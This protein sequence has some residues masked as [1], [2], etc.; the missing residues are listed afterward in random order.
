[1]APLIM[2]SVI[3]A[4]VSQDHMIKSATSTYVDDIFINESLVPA[5]RVQQHFWTMVWFPRS[6]KIYGV[7]RHIKDLQPV[8]RTQLSSSDKSNFED[9]EHLIYLN[10]NLLDSDSDA[11]CL[12]TDEVSIKT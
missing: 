3:N 4:I 11:S 2:K 5:S 7:P 6:V 1:M 9:S 8:I 10:S 12:P